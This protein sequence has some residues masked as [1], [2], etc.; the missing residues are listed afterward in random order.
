[1]RVALIH[2]WLLGER[3]G[4]K[5]LVF[6]YELQFTGRRRLTVANNDK[7][8]D[9]WQFWQNCMHEVDKLVVDEQRR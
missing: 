5:V 7:L 1:M 8:P 9:L 4:E 6:A 2:Y 3:G